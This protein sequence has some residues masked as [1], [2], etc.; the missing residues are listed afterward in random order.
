MGYSTSPGVKYLTSNILFG[1]FFGLFSFC[2]AMWRQ[3]SLI[4]RN[5]SASY[6]P[7]L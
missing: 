1:I 6:K 5:S 3:L 2:Y 7:P 4:D